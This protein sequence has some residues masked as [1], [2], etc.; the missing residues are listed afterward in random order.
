MPPPRESRENAQAWRRA[1]QA[2]EV[3]LSP[4]NG[5]SPA[6]VQTEREALFHALAVAHLQRVELIRLLNELN[7]KVGILVD[8]MLRSEGRSS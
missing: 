2:Q 4:N 6:P 7:A 5:A 1:R 3:N 8:A